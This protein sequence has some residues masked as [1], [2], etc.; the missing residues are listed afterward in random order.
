[1][2]IILKYPSLAVSY[3]TGHQAKKEFWVKIDWRTREI[4]NSTL[5]VSVDCREG[6]IRLYPVWYVCRGRE[7][8]SY[9]RDR[10][11]FGG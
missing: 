5:S 3:C 8:R 9:V 6:G 2:E 4:S 1:M 7:Q 10:N 11:G